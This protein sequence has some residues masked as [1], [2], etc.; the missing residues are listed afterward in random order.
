M[1]TVIKQFEDLQDY[2]H[3]YCVGDKFPRAGM[4]VSSER[5]KE[6]SSTANRQGVPLIEEDFPM[7]KPVVQPAERKTE[8]TVIPEE[9][10]YKRRRKSN[11]GDG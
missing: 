5:I 6:L 4:K 2:R 1:F 11:D 7:N 9:T 10:R 3:L 8:K